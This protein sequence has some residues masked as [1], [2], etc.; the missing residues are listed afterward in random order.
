MDAAGRPGDGPDRS[1][2]TATDAVD[3]AP[4]GDVDA[5]VMN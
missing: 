3:S 4:V 1:V 5:V 2:S